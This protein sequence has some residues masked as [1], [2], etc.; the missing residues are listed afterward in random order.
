LRTKISNE[1]YFDFSGES[2]LK[3]VNDYR[4]KYEAVSRLLDDNPAL[5]ALAHRDWAMLLSTSGKGRDGYTSEQLLRALIVMFVEGDSYRDVVI[6]IDTSEF[7]QYFVRLG[8]RLTMDFTFLNKAF[9]ALSARTLERMNQIVAQYAMQEEKISPAKQ[10]MD[11]TVYETNIHYPTDSSL[12]WDSFRTLASLLRCIQNELPQL[13]LQHRYHDKKVKK[14]ATFISR[15]A[16]SQSK[17]T[18]RKVKSQYRKLIQSVRWIHAVGREVLRQ[19]YQADY[20]A[21]EL[22]HYLPLVAR[23]IHQA[24]QRIIEGIIL[25][26]DEKLYSLFEEHTELI[27]RGKAGKPI[28]FGHK[29]LLAQTGEKFIH[30]YQVMPRRIEDKDLLAPAVEAHKELFG[31]YPDVLSTDK[32][33]YESMKQIAGLEEKIATVSIAK[34]GRR[35]QEEYERET[36]EAFL[37]GQSFRAGSEGSISVLKRAFK[38]GKCFF[39]GFKKYAASVGLAVLCHNLILLTRL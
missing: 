17:R 26:P 31:R 21:R 12:L 30:H 18:Q 19:V 16:S 37:D 28:E 23:I 13:N 7:L 3:I 10:R 33:F 15:N 27:Q 38:L 4:A 25:P 29:I 35:T 20:D 34:K 2:S 24:H 36:S 32:G 14:L 39:K 5:L 11:T 8:I 22:D 1:L 9:G 6:R